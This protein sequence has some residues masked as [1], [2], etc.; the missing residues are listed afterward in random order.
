MS[1]RAVLYARVSGD[2]THRDGRNLKG[3]LDTCR[4]HASEKG[5]AVVAELAEDDRGASGASFELPQLNQLLEMAREGKIDVV[6]VREIDRFSRR[7]AKQ[8]IVETELKRNGVQVEYVLD[9]YPDTPEGNLSKNIKAVIA[10]YERLKITERMVRG[11]R[12]KA[13]HGSVML[14]GARPPVGYRMV[15]I[16]NTEVL[17]INEVEAHGVRLAFEWYVHGEENGKLLSSRAIAKKLNDANVYYPSGKWAR[18]T[19]Q[20]VLATE[21]YAGTWHYGKNGWKDGKRFETP[22]SHWI[23]VD[24]PAIVD[25]SLWEAAEKRRKTNKEDAQRNRK[26]PYLLARRVTCGSCGAKMSGCGNLGT[27]RNGDLLLFYRCPVARKCYSDYT[28]NCE[29][30]NYYRAPWVDAA[31]WD[32]IYSLISEPERVIDGLADRQAAMEKELAPLRER[33]HAIDELIAEHERQLGKLLDLYLT[34]NFPQDLLTE[35]QN[36][37]EVTIRSLEQERANLA[38]QLESETMSEVELQSLQAFAASIA[39]GLDEADDRFQAQLVVIERLDVRVRLV[40]EDGE[41][42]AYASCM[43]GGDE[44]RLIVQQP[45]CKRCKPAGRSPAPARPRGREARTAPRR[46]RPARPPRVPSG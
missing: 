24:V 34:A 21:T 2:D 43:F 13:S 1:K 38:N 25:R 14:H 4:K 44:T 27:D 8:L 6:I 20:R 35:R 45:N 23:A 19:V 5:W 42:V 9:A 22:R 17:E 16:G 39:E 36:R 7:L 10:E 31:V 33:Q 11:R 3:Q 40:L 41:K 46:Q 12:Q 37:L 32:W 29:H 15:K 28:R 26:H 18:S 30:G